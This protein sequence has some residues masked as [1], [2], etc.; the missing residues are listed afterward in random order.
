MKRSQS[1]LIL[2]RGLSTTVNNPHDESRSSH[3]AGPMCDSAREKETRM[4]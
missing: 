1:P 2:F 3:E 4:A